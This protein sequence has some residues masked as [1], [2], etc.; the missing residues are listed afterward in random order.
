MDLSRDWLW[1]YSSQNKG[2]TVPGGLRGWIEGDKRKIAR[3]RSCVQARTGCQ[4]PLEP[5]RAED[6]DWF[7]QRWTLLGTGNGCLWF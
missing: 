1:A 7:F 5:L 2:D 4:I 6:P 3:E